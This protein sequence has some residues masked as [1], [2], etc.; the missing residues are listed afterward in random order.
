MRAPSEMPRR[1]PRPSRRFRIVGLIVVLALIFLGLSLRS[2]A[3]FYTDYLWFQSVHFTSVFRG[4]LV[5]KVL[6]A[7][8]FCVLFFVLMLGSLTVADRVAPSVLALDNSDELV[9][10]Y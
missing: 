2:L 5:T 10:R 9:E 4:V 8:V 3:S 1:L 6:L 7:V